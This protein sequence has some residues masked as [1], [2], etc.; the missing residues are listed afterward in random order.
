MF[1]IV[2]SHLSLFSFAL[3]DGPMIKYM[4]IPGLQL[5]MVISGYFTNPEKINIVKRLKLLIPFLLFGGIYNY[6]YIGANLWEMMCEIAK[7][8]YWFLWELVLFN[9]IVWFIHKCHI[10]LLYGFISVEMISLILYFLFLRHTVIGNIIGLFYWCFLLP[11][12]FGG[13]YLKQLGIEKLMKN[14]NWI[15]LSCICAVFLCCILRYY[16]FVEYWAVNITNMIMAFPTCLFLIMLTCTI[17]S[18]LKG[19]MFMGKS[20]LKTIGS[21]IG[22]YTLEIYVLHY[23]IIYYIKLQKEC[24]FLRENDLMWTEWIFS[25]IVAMVVIYLCISIAKL[26]EKLKVSFVFGK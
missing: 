15:L 22:R 8:G 19:Q 7:N 24:N 17:E 9:I 14:K 5:F 21:Q 20:L 3:G 6:I 2:M 12:F 23:Y 16:V 11:F 18:K 1:L 25:P 10:K 13:I 26:I 4:I